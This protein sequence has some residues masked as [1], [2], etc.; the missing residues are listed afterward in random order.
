[1]GMQFAM[2]LMAAGLGAAEPGTKRSDPL[3]GARV[4]VYK[5]IGEV[6]L[7]MYIFLPA[8]HKPTDRRGAVVFFFGGGFRRGA[9]AQFAQHCRYLASRGMVA[10]TADYRVYDRHQVKVVQCAADG[11]SAIR[12]VRGHAKRLG[13]DPD[14]IAAGGGSAGG[15]LAAITGT[16][17]AFDAPDEDKSVSSRPNAMLLFN[18]RVD[19]RPESAGARR[20]DPEVA[21]RLER[22][23]TD[24][25]RLSPHCHVKPGMAPTIIFHGAADKTVPFAEIERFD[26][27]MRQAK[28]RCELVAYEGKGHGFFNYGRDGGKSFVDTLRRTDRFLA[29]LGYL[30]GPPTIDT[31]K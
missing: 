16:L 23:G 17:D 21:A 29:S 4:E 20:D 14:R 31:Y 15:C 28:N 5:T 2:L 7:K 30:T 19:F 13:I 27:V 1:M 9:P 24:P 18:P 12:W 6:E 10:M 11:K 26:Q 25:E 8:D 22:L 3:A